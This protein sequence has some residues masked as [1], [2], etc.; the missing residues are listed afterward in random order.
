MDIF[1]DIIKSIHQFG[2]LSNNYGSLAAGI[3]VIFFTGAILFFIKDIIKK[4]PTLTNV[5]YLSLKTEK[6]SY[7]PYIGLT[8]FYTLNIIDYG[9]NS[10]TGYIEKTHDIENDG[11][12][13]VYTGKNRNQGTIHGSIQ[14]VYFGK[15]KLTILIE[16]NGHLRASTIVITMPKISKKSMMGSF[17]TT[18][19][20]SSGIAIIQ[21]TRFI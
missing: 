2:L 1:Y 8:S 15:N 6:S 19:A 17:Y 3:L 4:P 5:F 20:D 21:D 10:I 18:A 11:K 14:R 16:I 12:R 9:N 13:R 7:N